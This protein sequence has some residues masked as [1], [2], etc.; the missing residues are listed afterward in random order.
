MGAPQALTNTELDKILR[1]NSMGSKTSQ[2]RKR[3]LLLTHVLAGTGLR[4]SEALSLHIRDLDLEARRI[5]VE[6]GK[7]GKARYV[8]ISPVLRDRIAEYLKTP[9][10]YYR[11]Q[12]E[13]AGHDEGAIPLF[14]TKVGTPVS[15]SHVRGLMKKIA[16]RAGVDPN[17][18][19]P[20]A[21]RH[22]YA[23]R[24]LDNGGPLS[25]L[26]DQLGHTSITRTAIYLQASSRVLEDFTDR[27]DF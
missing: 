5:W 1:L 17:R 13:A 20:H 11:N 25:A 9:P 22:T 7:G 3:D 2:V 6:K 12:L 10:P 19:H 27:L 23:I 16:K 26:R 8:Y 4:V 21:F 14:T 24:F 15:A 18:L